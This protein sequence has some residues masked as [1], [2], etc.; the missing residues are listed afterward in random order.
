MGKLAA[1][2]IIAVSMLGCSPEAE[3]T[4]DGEQVV[5]ES[6][7]AVWNNAESRARA[8]SDP[9][10][11]AGI[12][13]LLFRA[14]IPTGNG[15][16][17]ATCHV[18]SKNFTISPAEIEERFQKNPNDPLFRSIDA[19]DFANDFTTVRTKG[20]FRVTLNLPSN[21]KLADDPA[22]K[23]V[24]VWRAV[25][26]VFN[27]K[28]TAPYTHDGREVSLDSQAKAA[29]FEH[30]RPTK[31][32]PEVAFDLIALFQERQFSSPIVKSISNQIDAG[33]TPP[34]QGQDYDK[35]LTALEQ[36]GF[37]QFLINCVVC[38]GGNTRE[39]FD[40]ALFPS[41]FTTVGIS[42]FNAAQLPV[43]VYE[44]TN[45]DGSVT[46]VPSPDPGRMLVTG[47]LLDANAFDSTQLRGLSK[48]AP[49]FHDNSK[50]TLT[51]V[52]NHYNLIFQLGGLPT[53]PAEKF[54]ALIAYLNR[55]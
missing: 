1:Y 13:E 46:S 22:A 34:A 2:A 29:A 52:L 32:L 7:E 21:V 51:D 9:S 33:Q 30:S 4:N 40:P 6:P 55:L 41:P 35:P 16:A 38:H 28:L 14:P 45:P 49:Y 50:A 54:P 39:N 36:E 24:Q 18:P 47:N 15:R 43:H 11:L 31:T 26:T 25:P 5:D 8:A 53:V 20:L 37:D 23:T 27:V 17:C 44:V 42:E 3:E 10:L 12:G 19:D 48:T